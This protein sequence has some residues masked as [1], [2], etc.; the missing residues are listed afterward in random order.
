MNKFSQYSRYASLG[1][2]L[3]TMFFAGVAHTAIGQ[4]N[5]AASALFDQISLLDS[6]LFT[7]FNNCDMDKVGSLFTEDLEFFHEKNGLLTTRA[8]VIGVMKQN[9][10]S[11]PGYKVRRELVKESLQVFEIK[12]Y[13]AI[14][15]GEHRFFL[16]QKNQPETLDG[17]GKFVH[18]WQNKDGVWR[19]SRVMSFGFRPPN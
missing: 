4:S 15:T 16:T 10:C 8:S 14:E 2:F 17:I 19:I 3:I 9:L 7:A 11:Q 5:S 12:G 1:T 18:L 6:S 13:G